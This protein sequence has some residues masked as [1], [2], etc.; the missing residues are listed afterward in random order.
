MRSAATNPDYPEHKSPRDPRRSQL[1]QDEERS[2][3]SG[4]PLFVELFG[5]L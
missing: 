3:K 1:G 4:L 2:D 5:V